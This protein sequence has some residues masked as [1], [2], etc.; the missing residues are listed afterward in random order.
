MLSNYTAATVADLIADINAANLAGGSNTIAL[1]AGN[2]FTLTAWDNNTNGFNGLPAIAAN[3][4]LTIQGNGDTITRS[5]AS[6]TEGF[7]LFEVASG[8]SL[9]LDNVTLQGGRLAGGTGVSVEGGAIFNQG[10]LTLSAAT[11][12][13]NSIVAS[14]GDDSAGGAI[15]SSGSL[16]LEGGTVIRNNSVEGGYG[17]RYGNYPG[18][19]PG[20]NAFGGGVYIAGG[21]ATLNNVTLS[22][23]TAYGGSGSVGGNGYGGALYVAGGTVTLRDGIVT[24]NSAQGGGGFGRNGK[25]GQGEGGGL[26]ID[27]AAIVYID[28]FTLQNTKGNKPTSIR[29]KYSRI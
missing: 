3:D 26:Y 12:Q 29:G 25:D 24:G 18:P 5:T 11:V 17:Y 21:T 23:N 16:T 1:V 7:R 6:G 19:T 28:A 10:A 2:T 27:P 4:N 9:T 22:G 20:G 14:N 8:A 15:Y 13:N